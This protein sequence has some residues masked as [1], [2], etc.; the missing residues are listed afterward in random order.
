MGQ[1]LLLVERKL[2]ELQ[3]AGVER[4]EQMARPFRAP[5][6]C[7]DGLRPHRGRQAA[8]SLNQAGGRFGRFAP[9]DRL[10]NAAGQHG[11]SAGRNDLEQRLG[12]LRIL[13]AE[14]DQL[15]GR[16]CPRVVRPVGIAGDG[17]QRFSDLGGVLFQSL[18]AQRPANCNSWL[19]PCGEMRVNNR[20]SAAWPS[21]ESAAWRSFGQPRASP[22]STG[23]ITAGLPAAS[24]ARSRSAHRP[25]R[26]GRNVRPR[27]RRSR[28]AW[29]GADD[30]RRVR[31]IGIRIRRRCGPRRT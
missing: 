30:R 13:P 4:L 25:A 10:D 20:A 26:G 14:F 17:Q 18:G 19:W 9:R 11:R 3:A 15:S 1:G 16:G 24:T 5:Q 22:E 8:Q 31:P 2:P 29:R 23:S 6:Q 7:L 21:A 27:G 28:R 12:H